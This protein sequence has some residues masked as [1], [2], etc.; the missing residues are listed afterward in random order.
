MSVR[1]CH[2][3]PYTYK[4]EHIRLYSDTYTYIY[5]TYLFTQT[6]SIIHLTLTPRMTSYSYTYTQRYTHIMHTI[7]YP[8]I[9]LYFRTDNPAVLSFS[10]LRFFCFSSVLYIR[11]KFPGLLMPR[12]QYRNHTTTHPLSGTDLNWSEVRIYYSP[13]NRL[14]VIP[15]LR[16]YVYVF[17]SGHFFEFIIQV[18]RS[19]YE[20]V[21]EWP[22]LK[23]MCMKRFFKPGVWSLYSQVNF[24]EQ[25]GV[26]RFLV[27]CFIVNS[28]LLSCVGSPATPSKKPSSRSV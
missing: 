26:M 21:F 11:P 6:Y 19:V 24:L 1:K 14:E 22:F 16:K 23:M 12:A 3:T 28:L 4:Y 27:K 15:G 17:T 9:L 2:C 8:Y 18:A 5:Y 25:S 7:P 20:I 10:V 13:W